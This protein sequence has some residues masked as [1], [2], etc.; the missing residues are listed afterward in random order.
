MSYN[1]VQFGMDFTPEQALPSEFFDVSARSSRK[2]TRLVSVRLPEELVLRL[3]VVGNGEGMTMS[4]TIRLVLERGLGSA[5]PAK[6]KK[7]KD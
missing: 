4:G 2:R 6:K 7:K 1:V 5:K 3:A